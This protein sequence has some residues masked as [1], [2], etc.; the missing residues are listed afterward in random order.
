MEHGIHLLLDWYGCDTSIT[1]DANK[2]CAVLLKAAEL[3]GC[4]ILH[5]YS[6]QFEP[7]GSTAVVVLAES[8]MSAHSTPEHDYVSLDVYTCM[9]SMMPQQ[10]LK[11]LHDT[12]KPKEAKTREFERG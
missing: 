7:Q 8:H 3:A 6:Y 2:L 9:P 10:A 1:N 11:Y 12:L 5:H 4:K